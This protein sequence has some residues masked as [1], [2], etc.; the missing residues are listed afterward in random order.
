[1]AKGAS[2][3][4]KS[5][6]ETPSKLLELLNLQ[7]ELKKHDKIILKPLLRNQENSTPIEF[8][9]SI[10]RFCMENKRPES[11][12]F[13][14]EGADGQDTFD[15]F[16]EQD[17]NKLAEKY[18][19]GLI[20]LNTT[21]TQELE[22]PDFKKFE[23]IHYPII[24][25]ENFV[26]SLTKLDDDLE[27]EMT[28]SLSNM[29]GAFPSSHYQGFFSNNKNKI[30]KWPIKYSI[31]DILKCKLPDFAII[32]ASEHGQILAGKPI[33]IDKQAAKLLFDDWKQVSHLKLIDESF[34]QEE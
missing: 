17:Y 31:H 23:T 19:V 9:E 16:E 24:L 10:L 22:S 4:F 14:V 34:Q 32:D 20:S 25:R 3:K 5:Y 6:E 1:M 11:E 12:I 28:G 18:S 21:E 30:R 13:I 8:V 33:E 15:L 27:T 2:I 7:S 26:I 29:L